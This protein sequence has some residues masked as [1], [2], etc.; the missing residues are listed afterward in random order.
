MKTAI[1]TK[2]TIEQFDAHVT[3]IKDQLK[4][5]QEKVDGYGD[6]SFAALFRKSGW[7]QQEIAD[8]VGFDQSRVSRLLCFGKFMSYALGHKVSIPPNLTEK[9]F[10]KHWAETPSDKKEDTRF[11]LII[12]SMIEGDV[13]ESELET[14][15]AKI[16]K[17][18]ANE[19]LTKSQI[20]E[21]VGCTEKQFSST[22]ALL[23]RQSKYI[24]LR[25]RKGTAN[26]K[27][28][29]RK[30]GKRIDADMLLEK[31]EACLI[32]IENQSKVTSMAE[33]A[34]AVI[35]M[36]AQRIRQI[37]EQLSK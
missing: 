27:Y 2:L 3:H 15:K 11:S 23:G 5:K 35:G 36:A 25:N 4:A 34:P 9:A 6:Q 16:V 28:K 10:R 1:E 8:K 31:L 17:A 37:L 12:K 24:V 30:A 19:F 22:L 7:T 32:D 20:M 26:A 18:A 33:Y 14:M 29:F 21:K 13:I